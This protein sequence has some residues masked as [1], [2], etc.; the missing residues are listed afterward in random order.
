MVPVYLV[1]KIRVIHR[2]TLRVFVSINDLVSMTSPNTVSSPILNQSGVYDIS[3][4]R[5]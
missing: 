5:S 2:F 3:T 1:I 4:E